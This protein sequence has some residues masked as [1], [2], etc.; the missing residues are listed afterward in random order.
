[1]STTIK[2]TISDDLYNELCI[3]ATNAKLSIQDYIRLELFG[4]SNTFT[5][6]D[7]IDLALSKYS[8]GDFFTV[9]EIFGSAWNLPNGVAGQFGR[10]FYTLVEAEYSTKIR[11]TKNF[12]AKKHAI[13]EIL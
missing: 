3:R 11:F 4:D 5:P 13:Y 8:K 1:M 2:F 10:K 7:A 9:P 12:N 6:Q